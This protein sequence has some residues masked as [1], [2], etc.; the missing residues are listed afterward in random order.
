MLT[1]F[2]ARPISVAMF[3]RAKHTGYYSIEKVFQTIQAALPAHIDARVIAPPL[4]AQGLWR[5]MFCLAYAGIHRSSVNHITGDISFVAVALPGDRTIVTI[6]DFDRLYRLHGIRAALFRTVYFTLPFRRCRFITTI[7]SQIAQE[8]GS[9]FPWAAHK[10]VVI[11]DCLPAGFHHIAKDFNAECP[12]ILQIGTKANKN[13]ESLIQALQGQRCELHVVGPLSAKQQSLLEQCAVPCRNSVDLSESDLLKAYAQADIVSFV[14]TYEGFG[15]PILEGNAVG[16]PV[17]T[18]NQ[19]PMSEV[20]G[21]AACLVDPY[22]VAAIREGLTRIIAD[23]EYRNSL[24]TRGFENVRRYS[25][26]EIARQFA[27]LYE[28]VAGHGLGADSSIVEADAPVY[29]AIRKVS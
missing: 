13:V 4:H 21:Q 27:S 25:A 7:S 29:T 19:P 6:H 24:V 9:L 12:V 26:T 16:R 20:A 1:T 11:P 22:S 15:L 18:S 2:K 14:S 17:I 8:L 10:M 3:S 5:R 23:P 28:T